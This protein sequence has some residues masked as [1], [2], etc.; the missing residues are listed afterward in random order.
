MALL[1]RILIIFW[2]CGCYSFVNGQAE[3][4]H[5]I[6][7]YMELAL[8]QMHDENY[9][10]ANL[11]FRKILA[12]G[13]VIPTDMTFLFSHTLYMI[14]QFQ[15]SKN[16]LDKY[17]RLTGRGGKYYSDAVELKRVLDKEI[18]EI[19]SCS[20][21]NSHGYRL[22]PCTVCHQTGTI[23]HTCS[24]CQGVGVTLCKVCD[25]SGVLITKNPLG[26]DHYQTCQNCE[27]KSQVDCKVCAG[28][29]VKISKCSA[30]NGTHFQATETL[31]DHEDEVSSY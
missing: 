25:G 10:A 13:E 23:S 21:C 22:Q 24:F 5:E 18:E 1:K 15:N 19:L 16:F 4:N 17:F 8:D 7:E 6:K 14:D 31:C 11:T 30:C 20:L 3:I 9:Q 26:E 28:K 2:L 27:G 12:S 29:K